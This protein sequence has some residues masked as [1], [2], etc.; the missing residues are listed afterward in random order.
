MI[1][2]LFQ[3]IQRII[4]D[5]SKVNRYLALKVSFLLFVAFLFVCAPTEVSQAATGLRLYNY[6]TKKESTYTGKQVIV[7]LNGSKIS[8]TTTPGI[9]IDGIALVPY[10]DVFKNSSILAECSYNKTKKTLSISKDG[11][12]II[13]K[14]GSKKATV[15]GKAVTLPVAPVI[16]K[17]VKANTS[18]ILV[19]SRYVAEALKM[20]YTW[21]AAKSTVAIKKTSLLLSYN[22]EA[23]FEYTGS[24][25]SVTIDGTKVSL[26]YMPVI[27]KNNTAMV[28]AEKVFADSKI[29]ADYAYDA[30][31]KT[32]TLTKG[33][34]VLVMTIG[35]KTA[36]LNG[37]T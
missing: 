15:N 10:T 28:R 26:G 2:L 23:E 7:T 17:Y 21:N 33:D 9:I 3:A 29:G 1:K 6:T 18:R 31:T 27:I 5:Y 35:S 14:I 32:V 12:I 19:P 20:D 25:G 30:T 34:I 36:Y 4:K 8:K 13:M 37:K 16:I 24:K 22:G 11:I